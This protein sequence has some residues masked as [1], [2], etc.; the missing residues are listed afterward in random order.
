MSY[1]QAV[2]TLKAQGIP[3]GGQAGSTLRTAQDISN[4]LGATILSSGG[5]LVASPKFAAG[6]LHM[7]G[8]RLVGESGPELEVTGPA[9]YYSRS[10]T[11]AMLGGGS[12]VAQEIRQLREENRAQSRA[13]VG[14]Q[15]R[16]TKLFEQ[17]DGS[18]LPETRDVTA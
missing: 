12:E 2:Q 9:R 13:L 4:F 18:G 17:W 16:M 14:L 5:S 8:M 3:Y 11:A 10:D 1:A 7:G 6:G 15:N